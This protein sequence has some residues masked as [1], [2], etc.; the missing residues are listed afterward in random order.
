MI[1]IKDIKVKLI[2]EIKSCFTV[3]KK[4]TAAPPAIIMAD[5][6]RQKGLLYPEIYIKKKAK[7]PSQRLKKKG[8]T[9]S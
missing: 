7:A 5:N 2:P 9:N 6:N 3:G 4:R 8:A 1:I